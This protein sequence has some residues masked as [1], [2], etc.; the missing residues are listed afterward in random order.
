AL[1]LVWLGL[2]LIR[3]GAAAAPIASATSASADVAKEIVASRRPALVDGI[4]VQMLNPKVAL[5]FI[6]FLPQFVDPAGTLPVWL[7]FLILGTIV[8]ITFSS[9]DALCV[10]IAGSLA[11]R[12][13]RSET[14]QRWS[15]RLG[16]GILVALGIHL[17][18]QKI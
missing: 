11:R 14:M 9:A 2:N 18:L 12:L 3:Q 10:L 8:N 16:G 5:F 6:A 15:R 1:Y 7:Q 13:A 17:S 4:L